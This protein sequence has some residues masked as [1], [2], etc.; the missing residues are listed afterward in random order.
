[1]VDEAIISLRTLDSGRFGD[2]RMSAKLTMYS[3]S[4]D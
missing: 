2:L 4:G 1:M 3:A